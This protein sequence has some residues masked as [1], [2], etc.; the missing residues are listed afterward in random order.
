MVKHRDGVIK[1]RDRVE[2]ELRVELA[3]I[4]ADRDRLAAEI[5]AQERIIGYRESVRW[6]LLLPWL[7]ARR[8][9]NRIRTA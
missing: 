8:F 4:I 9:W 5:A 7:R 6:W 3:Q 2:A 1:E